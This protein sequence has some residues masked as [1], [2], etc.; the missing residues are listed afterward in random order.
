MNAKA[1][2]ASEKRFTTAVTMFATLIVK[3][4]A[5]GCN[6]KTR[7]SEFLLLTCTV[8]RL[9]I[10]TRKAMSRCRRSVSVSQSLSSSSCTLE[11]C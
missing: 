8:K 9:Q 10:A 7:F 5:L 11:P 3:V 4:L 1:E 6:N 2:S